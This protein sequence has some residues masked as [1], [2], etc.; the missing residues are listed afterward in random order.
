MDGTVSRPVPTPTPAD[1]GTGRRSEPVAVVGVSCRFPGAPTPDAFWRLLSEGG[2]TV[3]RAPR[4]RR[5]DG[6]GEWG[7]FLDGVDRFDAPFFRISPREAAA[8]DPRQRLV[9]ELG[10][11]VLEDAG[12]LPAEV[13]GTRLGVFVGTL[14]D[15]YAHLAYRTARTSATQHTTTGVHRGIIANRLSHFL[16]VHGPSMTVDTGQSSSLVAVHLAAESLRRGESDAAVVAGVNLA[17]LAETTL[18]SERW[19]GLSPDG[20]CHTFD[21]RANG[22]VRGEGGGAV[23]LKPLSRA[24]ADGDHVYGVLLG[25]AV[26]NGWGATLTLP[27]ADA[28]AD[29]IRSACAEAG[30]AAHEVQYVELHGT[31]TPAGDPVEASA[32]GAALGSTRAAGDALRVGSVK[33]NIGH[34]EGA[35]GIAGLIKTLLCLDRR[36]LPASLN[37][38]RPHP[39][40]DLPG[41]GLAV[42]RRLTDWPHP[43]RPLIAGVSSFGMGGTNCHVVLTEAPRAPRALTAPEPA[44]VT[45]PRVL[46]WPV[47]GHGGAALRAQAGRLRDH[48]AAGAA[49]TS[50]K[51]LASASLARALATT[52]TRFGDRAVVVGRDREALLAGLA[53]VA[54]GAPAPGTVTGR[55]TGGGLAVLFS[56]QGSMRP[57][58]G[59]ELYAVHPAFADAFDAVCAALDPLIGRSLKETVFTDGGDAIRRTDL[60]QAALFAVQTALYRLVTALGVRPDVLAGHSVGELAAAHAAGILSLTD[61]CALVAARGRLMA[62]LPEGGAM[63]AVFAPEAEVLPLLVDREGEV[64]VA[65]V[66]GPASVV[67]SGTASALA[68]VTELLHTRGH[69]TRPL[70]V[71]HA[72]HSPL[73][74]PVLDEVAEVCAGLTYH[75][76]R[77]PVVSTVTGRLA[78]GTDLRSPE[79]WR[80]HVRRPVRFLDA[81]RT[82]RERGADTFLELGPDAVLSALVPR[83][84]PDAGPGLSAAVLRHG[85]PEEET[86]LTALG[87][88]HVRGAAV[89]WAALTPDDDRRTPLPTYAFQRRRHWLTE[90]GEVSEVAGVRE[91]QEVQEVLPPAGELDARERR[92]TVLDLVA[93]QVGAVLGTPADE[94]IEVTTPFTDLGMDSMA[95]VTLTESLSTATGVD[96]HSGSVYDFPTPERLAH[97]LADL[98]QPE[99]RPQTRAPA[100]PQ[101][102]DDDDDLIAVVGIGCRFP[103]GITTPHDLWQLLTNGEH[104]I[105][106][107]PTNRGWPTNLHHPDPHHPGTTYTNQG[108]FL[109]D[110]DQFDA[111]FFGISPREALAMDPQQ[112]SLLETTWHTLEHAGINPTTLHNTPTGVYVGAS[113]LEYG[114]RMQDAPASVQGHVMTGV[115]PSVLSGRL[116]YHFGFTGPA[117]TLD[118]ACSSSLVAIHTAVQALRNN[119]CTLALAGGTTIM[120]TPGTFIEFSR[121]QGL[122]PDGHCRSFSTHA[123]GTGWSEGTALLL[124]EPLTQARKNN[125]T[126]HALIKATA[127]NQDGPSNGLTAPNGQAQQHLITHTLTTAHLTPHHIDAIEAHGTATPLGDPIEVRALMATYGKDRPV[128][129]PAWLGSVKSNIGHTQAAAGVAGVIKMIEAM[130]H[131]TLPRTLHAQEPT[132]HVDWASS[133]LS[134]LTEPVAWPRDPDRPRR[135]AISSFG[136]S[137]TNAHLILQEPPTTPPTPQPTTPPLTPYILTAHTPTALTTHA[138]QLHTHLTTHHPHPTHTA[139]T[140]TTR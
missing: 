83:C 46:A 69:R 70:A 42:Q 66:N 88:I 120:S 22:Y 24:L 84:L 134:L 25:S 123:N 41:L 116:A 62:A 2:Q 1:G 82:V 129:R 7:S 97:H 122:S 104:A 127:T 105:T 44:P 115:S 21:A 11:E 92:R 74:D 3:R 31:G 58:A 9:L 79:Y 132:E 23:L 77:L 15:D 111:E 14:W 118:T 47:Y 18:L 45:N 34:L 43:D 133:G 106:D 37:F 53:A 100:T 67:L 72:F 20:R 98:L 13:A 101:P 90:A 29:A 68:E 86:L 87:R 78:E 138:Q 63:T 126:I 99:Q 75:P 73:M 130:R 16:R 57:G 40:I 103:G 114:P 102:N 109:H 59:R 71:A 136:I 64:S 139:H 112:R 140:L 96:L 124:L 110:A 89:D 60:G 8:M 108:G 51:A 93:R 135:A 50:D 52:R 95:A 131:E 137:G 81:V 19:G 125:H 119:E 35:A 76:P 113:P 128:G 117:L 121:L 26:T 39:A 55:A 5:A 6:D 32:L 10:W 80:G 94:P 36:R 17:L 4:E 33:T 85:R 28:Q 12:V 30:V 65:A 61:A 56:G 91:V 54:S 27:S 49:E 38:D 107:F 48:V